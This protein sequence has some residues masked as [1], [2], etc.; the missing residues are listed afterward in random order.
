MNEPSESGPKSA[1]PN[2]VPETEFSGLVASVRKAR[3]ARPQRGRAFRD[4][5]IEA[6]HA[7][8][9]AKVDFL[10]REAAEKAAKVEELAAQVAADPRAQR[11]YEAIKFRKEHLSGEIS[12]KAVGWVLILSGLVGFA[13]AI[14]SSVQAFQSSGSARLPFFASVLLTLSVVNFGLGFGLA[15]LQVWARTAVCYLAMFAAA[16]SVVGV[17][18]QSWMGWSRGPFQPSVLQTFCQGAYAAWVVWT[19]NQRSVRK[20]CSSKYHQA[21]LLTPHYGFSTRERMI[22]SVMLQFGYLFLV[23]ILGYAR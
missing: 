8:T 10:A 15:I 1:N 3:N 6:V 5:E 17:A 7:E 9:Q 23:G 14:S 22:G 2:P 13:I 20:A 11:M 21:V 4:E 16:S 19:L 12:V 18:A